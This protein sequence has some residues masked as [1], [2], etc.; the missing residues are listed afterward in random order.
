M[1]LHRFSYFEWLSKLLGRE[2][3]ARLQL[4][5]PR[6]RCASAVFVIKRRRVEA[7]ISIVQGRYYLPAALAGWITGTPHLMLVHD[8]FVSG[9]FNFD[10]SREGTTTFDEKGF[11]ECGTHLCRQSRNATFGP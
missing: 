6:F 9:L 3:E 8:N 5:N 10:S 1:S 4:S 2:T 7:L 11:G